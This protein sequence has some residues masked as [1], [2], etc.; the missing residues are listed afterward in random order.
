MNWLTEMERLTEKNHIMKFH[1][2]EFTFF[3]SVSSI[4]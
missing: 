1:Y 4:P 2:N 3:I